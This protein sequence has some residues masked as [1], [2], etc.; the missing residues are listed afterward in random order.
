VTYYVANWTSGQRLEKPPT[1]V[2]I[3]DAHGDHPIAEK[4]SLHQL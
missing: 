4:T 2:E 1:H 3:R